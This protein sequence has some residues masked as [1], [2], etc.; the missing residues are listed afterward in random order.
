MLTMQLRHGGACIRVG[1]QDSPRHKLI[2]RTAWLY[3]RMRGTVICLAMGPTTFDASLAVV[4]GIKVLGS[5]VA[6]REETVEALQL[7]AKHG[8]KAIIEI[9]GMNEIE[10]TMVELKNGQVKGRVVIDLS[11]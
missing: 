11:K 8:I 3:A 5:S 10:R 1:L 4:K 7:A 9:R 2:I 6:S